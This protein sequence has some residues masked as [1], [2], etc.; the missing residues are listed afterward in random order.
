MT[1]NR[2]YSEL[3]LLPTFEERFEYL[4]LSGEVGDFTFGGKRWLNQDFYRSSEWK[5]ARNAAIVRDLGL[6]LVVD[7]RPIFGKVIVHHINP[8]SIEDVARHS[9]KLFD[10]ENL[11]CVSHETHNAIHYG[12]SRLLTPSKIVIRAPNDTC[13]WKNSNGEG[14]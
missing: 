5:R 4:N 6:D 14:L 3:L 11:V 7:D 10:L 2:T 13:P 8:I 12:D 9:G 1:M